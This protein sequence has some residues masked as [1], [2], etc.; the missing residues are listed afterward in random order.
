MISLEGLGV[1]G[2][3]ALG[4]HSRYSALPCRLLVGRAS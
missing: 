1:E 4:L 2:L 3:G